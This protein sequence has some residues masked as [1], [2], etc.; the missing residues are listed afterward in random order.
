MIS[1]TLPPWL[2]AIAIAIPLAAAI[3]LI[4]TIIRR[5]KKARNER[6]RTETKGVTPNRESQPDA[7]HR[8]LYS[9]QI[10]A[11]FDGLSA[12]VETERIKLKRMI[13]VTAPGNDWQAA[14]LIPQTATK[15][16]A[17]FIV[18]D[19]QGEQRSAATAD[20]AID[21]LDSDLSTA[22]VE[23]VEK[24]RRIS[25]GRGKHGLEAVA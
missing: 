5:R 9:M 1:I 8:D 11:V 15:S 19:S 20:P 25:G 23:L 17:A 2:I 24:F 18:R 7:F 13:G 21:T 3:I 10:D 4:G 12:L 14:A 6:N 16:D 22:E